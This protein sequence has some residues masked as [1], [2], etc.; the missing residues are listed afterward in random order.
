MDRKVAVAIAAALALVVAGCGGSETR[1]LDGAALVREMQLACRS[2]GD[3]AAKEA[4]ATRGQAGIASLQ[5]GQKALVE[6]LEHIEATGASKADYDAYKE[7]V[8]A[9]LVAIEKV[10][11]ASRADRADVIRSVQAEAEAAGRRIEAAVRNL[12]VGTCG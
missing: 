1:T 3:A 8:R 4:R 10:V 7:G 5:A 6:R 11:S 9:R 2:A 12:G